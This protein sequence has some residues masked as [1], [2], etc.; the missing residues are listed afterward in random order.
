MD[1]SLKLTNNPASGLP[2]PLD[3]Q[4][5]PIPPGGAGGA[6]RSEDPRFFWLTVF[7]YV[8]IA[9]VTIIFVWKI[10]GGLEGNL[11]KLKDMETARGLIT[12]VITLGT[13][14]IAVMLALTAV[15]IRDFDKRIGVGREILTVLVG[16]LG[17]IV[18][19]Y[20]G[21]TATK[22]APAAGQAQ[23]AVAA[24]QVTVTNGNAV[25]TS[26]LEGGVAPYTY[27][28]KFSP[29]TIPAK[30]DQKSTD[31]AVR[32][33]FKVPD[34]ALKEVSVSIEG[35]DNNGVAF[36]YNKDLSVKIPLQP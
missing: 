29:T 17:T 4:Q 6:G 25:L 10:V 19:F 18:G 3:P 22:T 23:I 1:E 20:Y 7:Q 34:P 14:A 5:P 35:K 11:E 2:A 9:T 28:I 12:F 21:A 33:E 31:G 32:T 8:L 13:V 36:S 15:V 26:K 24:P 27:T 30:S 16:V